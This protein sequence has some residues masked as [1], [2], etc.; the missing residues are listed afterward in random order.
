TR[1]TPPTTHARA[2][3]TPPPCG[4]PLTT[5]L[6]PGNPPPGQT[7]HRP[8]SESPSSVLMA[9]SR[10]RVTT[11]PQPASPPPTDRSAPPG[12]RPSLRHHEHGPTVCST[13]P[14]GTPPHAEPVPPAHHPPCQP[15]QRWVSRGPGHLGAGAPDR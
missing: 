10:H 2:P 6:T 15:I 13:A 8:G 1:P 4:R 12:A 3:R 7:Q 9:H 11:P 5:P 14:A